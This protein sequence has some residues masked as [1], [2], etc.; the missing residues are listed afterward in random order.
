M[1]TN[2]VNWMILAILGTFVVL[3]GLSVLA[4]GTRAMTGFMKETIFQ[5]ITNAAQINNTGTEIAGSA[6]SV[7]NPADFSVSGADYRVVGYK[8]QS[9][10]CQVNL[11]RLGPEGHIAL[12]EMATG[13]K[14]TDSIQKKEW[15]DLQIITIDHRPVIIRGE[16]QIVIMDQSMVG[17]GQIFRVTLTHITC[18]SGPSVLSIAGSLT[19]SNKMEAEQL[20]VFME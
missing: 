10:D 3:C 12:E 19:H 16:E 13:L 9:G 17:H 20:I 14:E 7:L 18:N 8:V 5:N 6:R 4:T 11:L 15:L 2:K 1:K